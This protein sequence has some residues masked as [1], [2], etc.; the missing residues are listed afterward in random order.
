MTYM[1]Q[2]EIKTILLDIP[3]KWKSL[4]NDYVTGKEFDDLI[5]L[6][7]ERY[8]KETVYP[9]L[10]KVYAALKI[11]EPQD[12]KCVIIGQDPYFNEGQAN[13]LAF[14]VNKGTKLPPSL[15]NIYKE[16]FYEFGYPIPKYNGDLTPWA[17]QGVLLLNATLTVKAL[18]PNSH[19]PLGWSNFTDS[20]IKAL[21][22][23]KKPI[24]YLLW[25][26]YAQKKSELI[27]DSSAYIIKTA[28]PSPLSANRG[29]FCSDCFKKCNRFLKEHDLSPIDFQ[30]TDIN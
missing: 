1:D 26:N 23:L 27:T 24:V 15:Q 14:S 12:V 7:A 6:V 20:I 3:P 25:G 22:T 4:L 9:P 21:S 13:G 29:F 28:H 30:I 2:K 8:Q 11:V 5:N 17:M 19:Q 18:E 10:D 16:L